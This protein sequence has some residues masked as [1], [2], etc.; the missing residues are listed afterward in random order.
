MG[1]ST[2]ASM[3]GARLCT[4]D[5]EGTFR[6]SKPLRIKEMRN[7]MPNVN[8]R[9]SYDLVCIQAAS[10][11]DAKTAARAL[12]EHFMTMLRL[13]QSAKLNTWL[14]DGRSRFSWNC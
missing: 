8:I 4:K 12:F 14:E 3:L 5:F 10:A 6:W 13:S 9:E 2:A 1:R 7:S 11:T